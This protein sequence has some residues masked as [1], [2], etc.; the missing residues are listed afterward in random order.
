MADISNPL[1]QSL[2]PETDYLTYLTILE[3]NLD[4]EQLSTLHELLQDT[5]LTTN[6][7]WDLVRLLLPLLPE[8]D[9]CLQDVAFLGNP[10]ETILK[11]AELL[12]E[13][14]S[15]TSDDINDDR[16]AEDVESV[17]SGTESSTSI[18]HTSALKFQSLLHML[19]ILHP[20]IKTKYPS[21][22][23]VTSLRAVLKAFSATAQVSSAIGSVLMLLKT[24][25]G[26][27]RPH[28]PPRKS[29][30]AIPIVSTR[31]TAPDPEG[32]PDKPAPG[33][34]E[35]KRRILQSFMTHVVDIYVSSLHSVED[36]S[37]FAWASRY[38]EKS[39]PAR[40]VPIRQTF[41]QRFRDQE[42]LERR[43][44]TMSQLLVKL[45]GNL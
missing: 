31:I 25:S 37:A 5:T 41:R 29:Q 35:S 40:V 39:R 14:G 1:V 11:V 9:L 17:S 16:K 28:L 33:E 10:R 44:A 45:Y 19:C 6:I 34:E 12:E 36:D 27:K 20:R 23:L 21:R 42:E 26:S 22:F 7:G 18:T 32:Q 38:Y 8:S 15:K 2:P 4:K 3:Y 24:L 43:D 13:I 30:Q